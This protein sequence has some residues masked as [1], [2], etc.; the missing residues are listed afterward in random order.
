M[1]IDRKWRNK[2]RGLQVLAC[3]AYQ[4]EIFYYLWGFVCKNKK[5]NRN[6][7]FIES[8]TDTTSKVV[9]LTGA[10]NVSDFPISWGVIELPFTV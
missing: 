7:N 8:S 6:L 4:F 1:K 10:C 3:T 9:R 2:E 5:D